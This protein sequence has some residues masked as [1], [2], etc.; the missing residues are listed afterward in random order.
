MQSLMTDE[1]DYLC[2]HGADENSP[3]VCEL[4]EGCRGVRGLVLVPVDVDLDGVVDVGD[5]DEG[6]D[7]HRDREKVWVSLL[8]FFL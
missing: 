3:G 7:C 1:A 4:G 5:E 8:F 2:G 6:H